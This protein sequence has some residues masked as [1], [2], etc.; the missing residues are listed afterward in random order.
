MRPKQSND[1]TRKWWVVGA[2][3]TVAAVINR[4]FHRAKLQLN[5][6][7]PSLCDN[8]IQSVS[9]STYSC[10]IRNMDS[11]DDT[12]KANL[13]AMISQSTVPFIITNP[14]LPDNPIIL[15]NNEFTQLTGYDE[16]EILG[17]N[18]RF[19]TGKDTDFEKTLLIKNAI[20]NQQPVLVQ[21]INYKRDGSPFQNALMIAPLF[22]E[23]GELAYF[24]GSQME[25]VESNNQTSSTRRIRALNRVN[26]L[27]PQQTRVL[28]LVAKGYMNKQIAH[29]LKISE[30]TVKMHRAKAYTT[31]ETSTSAEAIR[32]AIEA[33]I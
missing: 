29:I 23:K 20:Q 7:I 26:L 13:T 24:L 5:S 21:L 17:K 12:F 22:D 15:C 4:D 25:F 10:H 27:S 3:V 6:K 14:R 16:A 9:I 32:L 1:S 30:S 31:L 2:Q 18:C 33:G 11:L 19:L 8:A 28:S